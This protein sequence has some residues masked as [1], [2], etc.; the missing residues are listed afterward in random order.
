MWIG[1]DLPDTLKALISIFQK[2]TG[3]RYASEEDREIINIQTYCDQIANFLIPYTHKS[4]SFCFPVIC[5][6]IISSS[7][8]WFPGPERIRGCHLYRWI[9]LSRRKVVQR[10]HDNTST[11]FTPNF[12]ITYTSVIHRL[13]TTTPMAFRSWRCTLNNSMDLLC[14]LIPDWTVGNPSSR[15][16]LEKKS[17]P[18]QL[19]LAH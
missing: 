5:H 11:F 18:Q 8:G 2:C 19:S 13:Y 12:N 14:S 1:I 17:H 4:H 3:W 10:K 7:R 16:L 15:L 9:G 6:I